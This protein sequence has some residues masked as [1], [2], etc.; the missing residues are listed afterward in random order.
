[1]ALDVGAKTIGTAF[2]DETESIAFPGQTIIRQ[3]GR[4]RDMAALRQLIA[5]REV[6]EIVVGLPLM[7]D[8]SHGIQ[9]EK[10]EDFV[11]MLRDSVRI[12]ILLQDERLST[13]EA[14]RVL[15]A[16]NQKRDQRKQTIDSLAACLLLQTHLDRRAEQKNAD[17]STAVPHFAETANASATSGM[18]HDDDDYSEDTLSSGIHETPA[19]EADHKILEET[20]KETNT[21]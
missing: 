2:S 6:R 16:G 19:S 11:V 21:A 13:S 10:I 4:K 1:M 17:V 9:T 14:E 20:N 3:E 15:I 7:M 12:P 8:G 18:Q 5:E